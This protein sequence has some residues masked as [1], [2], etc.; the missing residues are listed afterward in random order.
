MDR[1]K[2]IVSSAMAA[3]AFSACGAVVKTEEGNFTGDCETTNDILGPFFRENSPVRS[4]ISSG[5]TGSKI[6]IRGKVTK[7]CSTPLSNAKIEIWQCDT[8]GN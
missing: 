6:S 1:K 8:E 5:K 7:N 4:D 2:F 3:F